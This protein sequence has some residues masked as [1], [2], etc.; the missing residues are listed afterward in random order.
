MC[1]VVYLSHS[2]SVTVSEREI[3]NVVSPKRPLG[4]M[5]KSILTSDLKFHVEWV[6]RVQNLNRLEPVD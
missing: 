3:I 6:L 2:A 1:K 5:L 4:P